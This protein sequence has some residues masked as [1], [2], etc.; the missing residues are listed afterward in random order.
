MVF[1]R[2]QISFKFGCFLSGKNN[3][4]FGEIWAAFFL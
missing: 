4:G 2:K 1:D 3:V